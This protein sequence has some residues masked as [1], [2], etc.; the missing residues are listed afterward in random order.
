[1]SKA[2]AKNTPAR[3]NL[4]LLLG[5]ET[6][7]KN[8]FIGELRAGLAE[9]SGSPPEEYRFYAFETPFA[10]V[11]NLLR[12]A[13]LFA[14]RKLIIYHGAAELRK[15][16][17]IALLALYAK[18]PARDGVLVFTDDGFQVDK[19]LEG[20]VGAEG[21]RKF[22]ELF[23]S[24]KK[25]HVLRAFASRKVRINPAAAELFLELVD[26]T[27]T[28]LDREAA[29]LCLFKGENSEVTAADIETW[30]YH[31]REETVF[32]LFETAARLDFPASL[33]I[34][35]KLLVEGDS[36]PVQLLAGLLWNFRNLL[37][38][39]RL[40]A[41]R[42]SPEEAFGRLRIAS[43]RSQRV[44]GEGVK[45]FSAEELEDIIVLVAV[46]DETLRSGG[47]ELHPKILELFLYSVICRR[48]FAIFE[49]D[50]M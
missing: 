44:Y 14:A 15:K 8:A 30:L 13:S 36:N 48:G 17:D 39:S 16:D 42:V 41:E 50:R 7:K 45:N 22:W 34:L 47:A 33:E 40:A 5:P 31:S 18:N 12:N 25:N 9:E 26:N 23:E 19:K 29:A 27:T 38:Y 21:T 20:C 6:G 37:A 10:E 1:M 11:V 28:E 4:Y 2:G 46:C 24:D 3:R 43:K 35:A 49:P 32:S